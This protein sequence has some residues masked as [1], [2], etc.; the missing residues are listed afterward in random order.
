MIFQPLTLEQIARSSS[1]S[2]S[3]CARALAE[4]KITLEL[5]TGGRERLALEGFDPVFGARPLKRVVQRLLEN[6]LAMRIIAG[7]MPEGSTVRVEAEG[8]EIVFRTGQPAAV[9]G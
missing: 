2:S 4:R 6:P 1:C 5:T 3:R 7:E 9:G 8:D